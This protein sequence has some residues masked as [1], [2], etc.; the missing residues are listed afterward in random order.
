MLPD[1][2]PEYHVKDQEPDRG[3]FPGSDISRPYTSPELDD[4]AFGKDIPDEN[5]STKTTVKT[6]KTETV[7]YFDEDKE[8]EDIDRQLETKGEEGRFPGS[9]DTTHP[10]KAPDIEGISLVVDD[11]QKV[12]TE[13]KLRSTTTVTKVITE[14]VV[15]PEEDKVDDTKPEEV[16]DVGRFKGSDV[17]HPYKSPDIE[18]ISLVLDAPKEEPIDDERD[19]EPS[20]DKVPTETTVTTI[21]RETV[22]SEEDDEGKFRGSDISH[23]Y[24]SPEIEGVS[25]V[26]DTDERKEEPL[27]DKP[28][29]LSEDTAPEVETEERGTFK[30]SDVLRPYKTPDIEGITSKTTSTTVI[31]DS[32]PSKQDDE[33]EPKEEKEERDRFRGS[34]ISHPYKSPEIEGISLVIDLPKDE[35]QEPTAETPEDT[36]PAETRD[37][38][39]FKG[40]DISHPYKSPDI[41]GIPSLVQDI[42]KE[43][44]TE[45]K[46]I[47][48]TTVTTVVTDSVP[49]KQ[50]E[51]KQ[52]EEEKEE[53]DR[54]RGSDISHPY[55]PP[56]IEGISLVI[57]LPKDEKQEPT[58]ETPED[59]RPAETLRD[60]S[61]KL[62]EDT[63]P[64]VETEEKDTFKGS[65]I[66]HPYKAPDIEGI[67]LVQEMPKEEPKEG[68]VITKT[69][70]TTVIT[71]SVPSKL[72]EDKQPEKKEE[73]DRFRGSDISHP[74]KPPEIEGMTLV[75]DV[76]KDE[77]EER[78]R[79]TIIEKEAPGDTTPEE[80]KDRETFKGSVISHPY[81]SPDI[82]GISLV[83]DIPKEEPTEGK[84]ISTTTVTT[85]VSDSVPSKQD[86]DKQPEEEKEA[87]DRF[88][89]S[90]ISHPYKPPKMEGIT[91][92]TDVQ[93]DEREERTRKTI[94]EKEA[95]DDT[96]PEETTKDRETFKGSVISHPYKSPD[97]EG[98]SLVQDIPKEEPTE[99]KVISATTTTV[100]T[101]VTDSVP[102]K[103]DDDKQPEEE[104]DERDRF[105]GSDI[106]HTYKSPE[107]EGIA[108]IKDR[109][110]PTEV[111]SLTID[112]EGVRPTIQLEKEDESKH[113]EETDD[114][115][116]ATE[117]RERSKTTITTVVTEVTKPI[118]DTAEDDKKDRDGFKGS[119][120]SRPYKSPNIEG[121]SLVQEVSMDD[122]PAKVDEET[123]PPQ[124]EETDDKTGKED[125]QGFQG[126]S[127][128]SIKYKAPEI[129]GIS[130][131]SDVKEDTKDQPS[132]EKE[133]P[134]EKATDTKPDENTD[135]KGRFQES[136]RDFTKETDEDK[137]RSKTTVVTETIERTEDE[138]KFQGSDFSRP[139]KSPELEGISLV[140]DDS[141]E[142]KEESDKDK[143]QTTVTTV[144]TKT[145]VG[146]DDEGR[147]K[148]SEF[149]STQKSKEIEDIPL[150]RDEKQQ[151]PEGKERSDT[152]VTKIVTKTV[153]TGED[154]RKQTE[155]KDTGRFRGSSDVSLKYKAPEID[156]IK[157]AEDEK[158]PDQKEERETESEE[159]WFESSEESAKTKTAERTTEHDQPSGVTVTIK[160][161]TTMVVDGDKTPHDVSVTPTSKE[162][163]PVTETDVVITS[164][165]SLVT[166]ISEEAPKGDEVDK[167]VVERKAESDEEWYESSDG[168]VRSKTVTTTVTTTTGRKATHEKDR[169]RRKSEDILGDDEGSDSD[170]MPTKTKK[171]KT[172]V[173]TSSKDGSG[174]KQGK[175][176]TDEYDEYWSATGDS[177]STT[178]TVRTV[179]TSQK[180]EDKPDHQTRS[181]KAYDDRDGKVEGDQEWSESGEYTTKTQTVTTVVTRTTGSHESGD[182]KVSTISTET[183]IAGE[184]TE[185]MGE[186]EEV[187]RSTT[188]VERNT[189]IASANQVSSTIFLCVHVWCRDR[190]CVLV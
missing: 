6:T 158:E 42:P 77:R 35:K 188:I 47:S 39:T 146:P 152:T 41:E 113:I 181:I 171:V 23:P 44:P 15:T 66:S 112:V 94:I 109:P 154:V 125:R 150:F 10:Y 26:A 52:P 53:R 142:E 187:K 148:G 28:R 184:G 36:R 119:D 190:C 132:K 118:V 70:V 143:L 21:I 97:I 29:K 136:V 179:V 38:D 83:Q 176:D 117:D 149:S 178:K 95:P 86:D 139:Y 173:R 135:E 172:I 141:R 59:T 123:Q 182:Q 61:R 20:E 166:D 121:I 161:T 64:K 37:R 17:S 163:Q 82:E 16:K 104:K 3:T 133:L 111:S 165:A 11:D 170:E 105:R 49:S 140:G 79:K 180:G 76:P 73:R 126:R 85:I 110:E 175:R 13:D 78:T 51:D 7:S 69:T 155:E 27:A 14:K 144:V 107:I 34:D 131:I 81:K 169:R 87:R 88:R 48:T 19:P 106:S 128:I 89:G 80:T 102:S 32:V 45:G 114:R 103:Q 159:E 122:E 50:D 157:L 2:E 138:E 145:I 31:T 162:K 55:K 25:L 84:V 46:V 120:I 147:F 8:P 18:G 151:Q 96:T 186:T 40:S 153:V 177:Y 90:D 65:D 116:R 134:V 92:V 22:V 62:S 57:D 93:K 99:G 129:E 12:P 174:L 91:L 101:V 164:D 183:G 71:D 5:V 75:T 160:K 185:S 68:N 130:L 30:G 72:D 100:T 168:T 74:Y 54:F 43:E 60:K 1:K 127:D 108:L 63:A 58:A 189:N 67:S 98:I 167:T 137:R 124:K 24:K 4:I 156:E 9:S 33:Q 115:P 56:E